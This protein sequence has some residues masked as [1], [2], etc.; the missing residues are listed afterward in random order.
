MRKKIFFLNARI[1]DR[2][3]KQYED[4]IVKLLNNCD[5]FI[6]NIYK[7]KLFEKKIKYR[8]IIKN[9]NLKNLKIID[10]STLKEFEEYLKFDNSIFVLN[11]VTRGLKDFKIFYYLKKFNC[12]TIFIDNVGHYGGKIGFD[13]SLK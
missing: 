1:N 7:L 8:K 11:S 2:N 13:T 10:I 4:L 5:V 12:F 6:L 3:H 9:K